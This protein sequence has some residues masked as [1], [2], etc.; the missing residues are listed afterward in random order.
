[1]DRLVLGVHFKSSFLGFLCPSL[2]AMS[3]KDR[4]KN[5]RERE[6]GGGGAT[7][8]KTRERGG[9]GRQN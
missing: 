1:M 6:R 9:G 3:E 5:K 2:A 8:L 4:I 7:E